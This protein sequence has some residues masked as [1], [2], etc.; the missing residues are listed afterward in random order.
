MQ[1]LRYS[2]LPESL[3]AEI[4]KISEEEARDPES[5]QRSQVQQDVLLR[6]ILAQIAKDT[7]RAQRDEAETQK[8]LAETAETIAE[9]QAKGTINDPRIQ[10]LINDAVR[11]GLDARQQDIDAQ[12]RA[13]DQ[14]IAALQAAAPQAGA[15]A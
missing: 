12:F 11:A 7:A 8:T 6:Q 3:L 1:L 15:I 10:K 2:P 13:R 5:E 14:E 9:T 4:E